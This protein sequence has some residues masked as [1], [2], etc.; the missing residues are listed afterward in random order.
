TLTA[1]AAIL[2]WSRASEFTA[3][4]YGCMGIMDADASC[5]ALAKLVATS[6][7]LAD[8]FSISELEKQAERLEDMETSSLLGRLTRLL[9][10]LEDT[11]P[12]IPQRTVA[13]RE[14]AGSRISREVAAGR[15]FKAPPAPGIP[16]TQS[17]AP[18]QPPATA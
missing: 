6:T 2:D 9:S 13:L 1:T 5:M 8:S 11:H 14:W 3:D 18:P 4:R 12:M 10:M 15:V 17:T 16:G 7:S